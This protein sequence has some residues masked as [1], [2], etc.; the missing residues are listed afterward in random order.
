MVV[1][2]GEMHRKFV[3]TTVDSDNDRTSIPRFCILPTNMVEIVV[4]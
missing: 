4:T 3:S 2:K 1:G